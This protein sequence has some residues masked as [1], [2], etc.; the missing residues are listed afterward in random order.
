M[1][2]R[3]FDD[4]TLMAFADGELDTEASARIEAAMRTDNAL[5]ERVAIFTESRARAAAALK[6]LIE[7]PVPDALM[8]SIRSMVDDAHERRSS[9][10][11]SGGNS[12]NVVPLP[13]PG[14]AAPRRWAM[15]LAASLA[16]AV[17][18]AG[19]YF[20]G[21]G[22][23]PSSSNATM[24]WLGDAA[25]GKALDA[26]PSGED[27]Q[28]GSGTMRLVSSFRDQAGT[29]CRELEL[30]DAATI[31]SI[32]CRADG[33]WNL[34]L[35]VTAPASGSAYVPAGAAETVDAYLSTIDAGAPLSPEEE[36]EALRT[37]QP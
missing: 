29:F 7:E 17:A 5:A 28:T 12:S 6:P 31:V 20:A 37:L 1:N 19:G 10:S 18:A 25:V 3:E 27:V 14:R 13:L 4:E 9:A 22:G 33:R 8:Q 2:D 15:P 30:T 26:T 11:A 34:R 16:I 35:T 32:V 23:A 24:A 36:A 21:R